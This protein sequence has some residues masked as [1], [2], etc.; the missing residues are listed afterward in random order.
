MNFD[1]YLKSYVFH[2]APLCVDYSEKDFSI[3]YDIA[4][5]VPKDKLDSLLFFP[6]PPS[7][8]TS[9]MHVCFAKNLA[10]KF[11][12]QLGYVYL[13]TFEDY[14]ADVKNISMGGRMPVSYAYSPGRHYKNLVAKNWF[15]C[16][17]LL[18][19]KKDYVGGVKPLERTVYEMPVG[20]DFLYYFD[21][22]DDNLATYLAIQLAQVERFTFKKDTSSLLTYDEQFML[23]MGD[24]YLEGGIFD[25]N[26]KDID[27]N[28]LIDG[29][30]VLKTKNP[31]YISPYSGLST[32]FISDMTSQDRCK[33]D[34][35]NA[36]R[37]SNLLECLVGS[38]HYFKNTSVGSLED[39]MS[40]Q[41][42]SLVQFNKIKRPGSIWNGMNM[43]YLMDENKPF[44]SCEKCKLD[45][46]DYYQ[47]VQSYAEKVAEE[48]FFSHKTIY[49]DIYEIDG[50][51]ISAN[52]FDDL[53]SH[54]EWYLLMCPHAD[55]HCY[56]ME[57]MKDV[58]AKTLYKNI[59]NFKDGVTFGVRIEMAQKNEF[60]KKYMGKTGIS[61]FCYEFFCRSPYYYKFMK[62][63]SYATDYGFFV[64]A[65]ELQE[66]G[67]SVTNGAAMFGLKRAV[68]GIDYKKVALDR[69]VANLFTRYSYRKDLLTT[70]IS[71][72]SNIP[73]SAISKKKRSLNISGFLSIDDL[74]VNTVRHGQFAQSMHDSGFLQSEIDQLGNFF[75]DLAISY[76]LRFLVVNTIF[77]LFLIHLNSFISLK[78]GITLEH[79]TQLL[80][81]RDVFFKNGSTDRVQLSKFFGD[82]LK[83]SFGAYCVPTYS[84]LDR[85][86]R[87]ERFSISFNEI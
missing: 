37:G 71:S 40:Y 55:G 60:K 48:L 8:V 17:S 85:L 45:R 80:L 33:Y 56:M 61:K 44:H 75:F 76:V 25:E 63:Y 9:K 58:N 74:V 38:K 1:D 66:N 22:N 70:F 2:I 84:R 59:L 36:N 54:L 30:G 28:P 81:S 50:I 39:Y 73:G 43:Y 16:R 12:L 10:R 65:K 35:Y 26:H 83:D 4:K 78:V 6:V 77:S 52:G 7:D 49:K 23:Q 21:M 47:D 13:T 86:I 18:A 82:N 34:Y 51:F 64:A 19:K 42:R 14:E 31:I 46:P 72:Y 79:I 69:T 29:N 5:R 87:D 24:R 27:S 32:Y 11:F 53:Q 41:E 20:L 3:F 68:P 15:L 67:L 62:D 57:Y